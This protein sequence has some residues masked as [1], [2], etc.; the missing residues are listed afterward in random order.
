MDDYCDIVTAK[1]AKALSKDI[2]ILAIP[3]T[4]KTKELDPLF[5]NQV[6]LDVR[7]K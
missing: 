1:D 4:V 5:A 3:E 6:V 2:I 7:N